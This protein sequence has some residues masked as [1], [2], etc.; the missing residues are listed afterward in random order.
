MKRNIG[1][2]L[3][4]VLAFPPAARAEHSVGQPG[5]Q[6]FVADP[7]TSSS[8]SPD[9][10]PNQR[11]LELTNACAFN[12]G[13]TGSA[14]PVTANPGTG[15]LPVDPGAG[16]LEASLPTGVDSGLPSA[17]APPLSGAGL[18][19]P[20]TAGTQS[21]P[22]TAAAGDAAAGKALYD[23]KCTGCH[24]PQKPAAGVIAILQGRKAPPPAMNAVLA[25]LSATDKANII[26]YMKT[27]P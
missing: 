20:P 6:R 13:G 1:F 7:A 10:D 16:L 24:K 11:L 17:G 18:P 5:I 4:A 25:G 12:R 8:T 9:F 26:A 27:Q 14:P 19:P 3:I 22:T 21:P 15:V 23:A 2:A